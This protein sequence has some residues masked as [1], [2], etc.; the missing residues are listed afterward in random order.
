[1]G[2]DKVKPID[3]IDVLED[4]GTPEFISCYCLEGAG[5][6]CGGCQQGLLCVHKTGHKL[7]FG[8]IR[9]PKESLCPS[10]CPFG[11]K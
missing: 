5:D 3:H 6:L 2:V 11:T 1:M 7:L 4:R 9:E 8:S 10:V